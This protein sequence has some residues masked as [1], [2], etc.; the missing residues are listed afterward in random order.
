[1]NRIEIDNAM[2]YRSF[3]NSAG[4]LDVS[5]HMAVILHM[6]MVEM[7]FM[8]LRFIVQLNARIVDTLDFSATVRARMG[9]FFRVSEHMFLRLIGQG[10]L[11]VRSLD[12]A[13]TSI[14]AVLF[15]IP[16]LYLAYQFYFGRGSFFKNFVSTFGVL[17][18]GF[19]YFGRFETN[20]V[21]V[22]RGGEHMIV[23]ATNL[24]N[25]LRDQV[26]NSF[27][28]NVPSAPSSEVGWN[29]EFGDGA[30]VAD[31]L[32]SETFGEQYARSVIMPVFNMV[33][34]GSID[35][36]FGDGQ[37]LNTSIL[38]GDD[39]REIGR[40]LDSIE[41]D[42]P[43]VRAEAG[44]IMSMSMVVM[45]GLANALVLGVPAMV[46]NVLL[47]VFEIFLLVLIF[48]FP[49]AWLLSFIPV[50]RGA[51]FRVVKMMFGMIF[52]PVLIAFFLS[53]FFFV[54]NLLDSIVMGAFISNPQV[55]LANAHPLF[56]MLTPMTVS[57]IIRVIVMVLF[58]KY[59][60]K[61]FSIITDKKFSISGLDK[62]ISQGGAGVGN[63]VKGA[64]EVGVG[65]ATGNMVLAAHGGVDMLQGS[66]KVHNGVDMIASEGF[67]MDTRNSQGWGA[68]IKGVSSLRKPKTQLN[69][70]SQSNQSLS[71]LSKTDETIDIDEQLNDL[72]GNAYLAKMSETSSED[73]RETS[74]EEAS[75][76]TPIGMPSEALVDGVDVAV[77]ENNPFFVDETQNR[78]DGE[79]FVAP[80]QTTED[81]SSEVGQ[82]EFKDKE[83]A[84]SNLDELDEK[85][86]PSVFVN[87]DRNEESKEEKT[88]TQP[89]A[90]NVGEMYEN[91]VGM[92]YSNDNFDKDLLNTQPTP[93]RETQSNASDFQSLVE[94]YYMQ[95]VDLN[96]FD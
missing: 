64:A 30:P 23:L 43:F 19:L 20:T 45:V 34:T 7:P 62:G 74:P 85:E 15:F 81:V 61:V 75:T 71:S 94:S 82:V 86:N 92:D 12:I 73:S 4:T 1:M 78:M 32:E 8:A 38:F 29:D 83:I 79:Q 63:F 80:A 44:N 47:G 59:K 90:D 89:V 16:L 14:V 42:N 51:L 60:G 26:N 31:I 70:E 6:L 27:T 69:E 40:Y 58:M 87:S 18:V 10:G 17:L 5:G 52:A 22:A 53:L 76:E 67:S 9:D 46:A 2:R 35:G 50:M 33:N 3:M 56:T 95:N 13:R 11:E 55:A 77:E 84:V 37:R 41:D 65:V 72:D 57:L 21:G 54:N 39:E 48:L 91:T 49:L 88:P 93:Q 66:R 25:D 28:L 68:V 96:G 36:V 24:S